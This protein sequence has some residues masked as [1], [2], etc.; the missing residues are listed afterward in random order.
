MAVFGYIRKR[1]KKFAY[2]F[3]FFFFLEKRTEEIMLFVVFQEFIYNDAVIMDY[4]FQIRYCYETVPESLQSGGQ[5]LVK[6][7]MLLLLVFHQS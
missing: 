4:S 2:K 1:I 7:E 3:C 6:I 5:A